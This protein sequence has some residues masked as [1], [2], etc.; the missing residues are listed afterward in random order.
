MDFFE[1]RCCQPPFVAERQPKDSCRARIL[2][3]EMRDDVDA[4][5]LS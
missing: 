2:W 5:I 4:L 3:S 1:S